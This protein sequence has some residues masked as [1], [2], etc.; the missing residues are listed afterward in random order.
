[1]KYSILLFTLASAFSDLILAQQAVTANDTITGPMAQARKVKCSVTHKSGIN[2]RSEDCANALYRLSDTDNWHKFDP[3]MLPVTELQG[4]CN[5]TVYFDR[6]GQDYGS[7]LRLHMAA[8]RLLAACSYSGTFQSHVGGTV[9]DGMAGRIA[10][11]ISRSKL[12]ANQLM[13]SGSTNM[14]A[15]S[16]PTALF[17]P[18][19]ADELDRPQIGQGNSSTG[20]DTIQ[21]YRG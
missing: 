4:T 7:W 10:I 14:T 11:Q 5:V 9:W 1:M 18:D 17:E 19:E 12:V 21:T 13:L 16:D 2:A 3:N 6:A 8:N 15:G 20:G